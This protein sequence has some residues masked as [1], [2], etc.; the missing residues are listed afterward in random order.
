MKF[1]F[2]KM[3]KLIG[4]CPNPQIAP[5]T[6]KMYGDSHTFEIGGWANFRPKKDIPKNPPQKRMYGKRHT[7]FFKKSEKWGRQIGKFCFIF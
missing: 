1:F 4:N 7:F 5:P 2:S 3:L 6:E